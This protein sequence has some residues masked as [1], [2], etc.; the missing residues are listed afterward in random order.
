MRGME[1]YLKELFTTYCHCYDKFVNDIVKS[2][3]CIDL[4][5]NAL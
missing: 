5:N 2:M 1:N 4:E 3:I